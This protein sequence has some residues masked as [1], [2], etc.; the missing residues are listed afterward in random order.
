MVPRCFVCCHPARGPGSEP[1]VQ[2]GDHWH[3]TRRR[4][5]ARRR[6]GLELEPE[7]RRRPPRRSPGRLGPAPTVPVRPWHWQPARSRSGRAAGH[8]DLLTSSKLSFAESTS[9]KFNLKFAESEPEPQARSLRDSA[10]ESES[11]DLKG[12]GSSD[13]IPRPRAAAARPGPGHSGWLDSRLRSLSSTCT[14][15]NSLISV[16]SAAGSRAESHPG[17]PAGPGGPAAHWQ[18]PADSDP[19]G[20]GRHCGKL[21][22]SAQ[23]CAGPPTPYRVGRDRRRG[24]RGPRAGPDDDPRQGGPGPAQPTGSPAPPGLLRPVLREACARRPGA[25]QGSARCG[26]S[27]YLPN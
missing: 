8:A 11:R 18:P 3:G 1:Q 27:I 5:R 9:L 10:A 19:A 21:E 12:L 13:R 15:T 26:P 23:C 2:V 22:G 7:P 25:G 16:S 14:G 24:S 6:A 4:R 17:R 20:P